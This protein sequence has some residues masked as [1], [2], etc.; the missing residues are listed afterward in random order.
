MHKEFRCYHHCL[1][2]VLLLPFSFWGSTLMTFR[3]TELEQFKMECQNSILVFINSN[4]KACCSIFTISSKPSSKLL[5][6]KASKFCWYS[7][8]CTNKTMNIKLEFKETPWIQLWSPELHVT[9]KQMFSSEQPLECTSL[10]PSLLQAIKYNSHF[11]LHSNLR[12]LLHR[13]KSLEKP[14]W[15]T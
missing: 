3:F 1:C 4:Q 5:S 8:L 11:S 7:L 15:I 6:K 9:T 13:N 2:S 10:A 12:C 14:K